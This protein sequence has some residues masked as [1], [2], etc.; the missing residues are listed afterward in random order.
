VSFF[1]K[2]VESFKRGRAEAA[3]ELK[4][5]ERKAADRARRGRGGDPVKAENDENKKL[6]EE[7]AAKMESDAGEIESLQ[8]ER[9]TLTAER[10]QAQ[11][12]LDDTKEILVALTER[13]EQLQAERDQLAAVL[14]GPGVRK[15]LIRNFH[16]D[17]KAGMSAAERKTFDTFTGQL[18]AAY[19]LIDRI[20]KEAAEQAEEDDNAE[21]EE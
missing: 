18:N 10:D 4:I 11:A 20:D 6:L 14:K 17:T 13:A 16:S 21:G 7:A 8:T 3:A 12:E 9:D 2:H 15:L 1:S 19:D 5:E